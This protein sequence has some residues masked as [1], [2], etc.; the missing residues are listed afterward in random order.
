MIVK[1]PAEVLGVK[2][3]TPAEEMELV[4]AVGEE[5]VQ[6]IGELSAVRASVMRLAKFSR[7]AELLASRDQGSWSGRAKGWEAVRVRG[8]VTETEGR[9]N[10]NS[11]VAV[12]P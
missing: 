11:D 7:V 5:M 3:A 8:V 9:A 4:V 6:E 1:V 12:P 2:E 10:E